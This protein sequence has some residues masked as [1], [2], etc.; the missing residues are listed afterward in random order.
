MKKIKNYLLFS[1]VLFAFIYLTS[2]I[3]I[4]DPSFSNNIIE[5]IENESIINDSIDSLIIDMTQY[6]IQLKQQLTF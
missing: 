1:T 2:F 4:E 5:S 3:L 6:Y